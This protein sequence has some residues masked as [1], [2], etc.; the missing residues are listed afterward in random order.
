[1][2]LVLWITIVISHHVNLPSII[3]SFKNLL[4]KCGLQQASHFPCLG[5]PM[6]EKIYTEADCLELPSF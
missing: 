1:M 4:K 3:G 6:Q 5:Q 2:H